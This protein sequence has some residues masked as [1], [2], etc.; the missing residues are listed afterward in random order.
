V[1]ETEWGGTLQKAKLEIETRNG[2][3]ETEG[4]RREISPY[5]RNDGQGS[6]KQIPRSAR[7]DNRREGE[8][9]TD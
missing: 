2:K 8:D 5:G 1:G 7:D 9:G 3:S 4:R 6:E